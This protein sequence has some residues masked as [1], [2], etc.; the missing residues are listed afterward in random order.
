ML[1]WSRRAI[2]HSTISAYNVF[3]AVVKKQ[4]RD[5]ECVLDGEL[6]VWNKDRSAAQPWWARVLSS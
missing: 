2:E 1:Y 3:D 6:I 4:F 5:K